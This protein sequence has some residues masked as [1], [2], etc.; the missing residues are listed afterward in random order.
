[1]R[2]LYKDDY[3]RPFEMKP[4]QNELFDC[5]FYRS[6]PSGEKRIH[7]E[8]HTQYG[9]SDVA[10]MA[11][12]TRASTFAEKWPIV[13]PS[14]PKARIIMSYVIKHL[15]ENEYT[16]SRFRIDEG[17]SLDRL[18]RER[19]KNRLT[20][21]VG[22]NQVS[23]IFILSAE[24]RLKRDEDVGDALMGFGAPNLV[25][26]E[27]ALIGDKAEA[28]AMRMV[29]GHVPNDFVIKI[30]NPFKRNHFLASFED[31][32][33]YK[34]IVD[35]ER[36]IHEGRLTQE[37]IEEMRGKPFFRVLYECKFPEAEAIDDRGWSPILSD[38]DIE[39][40]MADTEEVKHAGE[41]RLGADIARTGENF[42]TFV[43]RSMNVAEVVLKA[44]S[45]DLT[46][47]A[48]RVVL[49]TEEQKVIPEN[50]F[51]DMVGVGAGV[52]DYL[53]EQA[54]NYR[55][56]NVGLPALEDSRYANLRAEAYWR[57]R[58]WIKKGGKLKPHEDWMQLTKIRYKP[59]HRGRIRVMSKDEMR[60]LGIDS[61][62]VA[63]A[64]MLT[65]ARREHAD[66]ERRK[67]ARR[68]KRQKHSFN[69]GL[70]VSMGGF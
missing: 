43:L 68:A 55:G 57:M 9:K 50:T 32:S 58:E 52:Y 38:D 12:L 64:L 61:P 59:D 14:Q 25:M 31:A 33:Y 28:K 65:F 20:F 13:A 5:I 62:D 54:K 67:Q 16:L 46:G 63:D 29:G 1:M 44:H 40:A 19:S 49:T 26:D 4:G 7:A 8:T 24:S 70:K 3:G 6:G 39:R 37:F 17:E 21:N 53:R 18:R 22:G 47:T 34:I 48:G 42:T 15:F 60:A 23:E 69:R 41:R 36:G 51:I 2:L 66:M 30:G 45:P 35:Y 27:A 10:A 11:V 56:V